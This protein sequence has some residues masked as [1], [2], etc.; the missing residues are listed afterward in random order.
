MGFGELL[1]IT[2]VVLLFFGAGKLKGLG[3]SLGKAAR[4][5]KDTVSPDRPAP[6][7]ERAPQGAPRELPPEGPKA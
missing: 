1:L 6:S 2:F 3:A 4:G 7:P 5:F